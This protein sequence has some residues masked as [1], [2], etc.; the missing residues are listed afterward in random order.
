LAAQGEQVALKRQLEAARA[1]AEAREVELGAQAEQ[2]AEAKANLKKERGDRSAAK[3]KL[4]L[5]NIKE[6]APS[7]IPLNPWGIRLEHIKTQRGFIAGG[8]RA[9]RGKKAEARNT[10]ARYGGEAA[11]TGKGKGS[12]GR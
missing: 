2:L 8:S 10:S 3:L 9:E 1:E 4:A 5:K 7:L 12:S 11:T 6:E